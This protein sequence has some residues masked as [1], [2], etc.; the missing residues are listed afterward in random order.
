VAATIPPVG[1]TR[2][3]TI[4]AMRSIS[5][6]QRRQRLAARHRLSPTA[7]VDDDVAAVA[8][9]VVA[10]HASDPATMVLSAAQ[11]MRRPSTDAVEAALYDERT[12]VR[13]LG[14]RRT[15]FGVATDLV[16][17]VQVSSGDAVAA[18]ERR[19]L[20]GMLRDAGITSD[21]G[22]WLRRVERAVLTAIDAAG[23]V[24]AAELAALVPAMARR[25]P[26]AQGT[27]HAGTIGVASKV[28]F[29]L[30]AEGQLVRGRP[31]GRWTS[32]VHRWQRAET[33]LGR[34]VDRHLSAHEARTALARGWLERF[35]PATVADLRW[36]TGWTLGATRAALAALEVEEVDLDGMA[37]LVLAD[38]EPDPPEVPP[39]VALLPGLD[40]T[41]MGWKARAWYLGDH[42][43][44]VFDGN[45]NA[46]PTVWADG[47]VVGGWAQRADGEVVVRLLDDIGGDQAAQVAGE[48]SRLQDLL[49]A[50]RVTPRFPSPLDRALRA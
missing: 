47:R 41:T 45:G 26:V 7:R 1:L 39:W 35:G 10:L 12:V 46:G 42:G 4:V 6:A 3:A 17:V 32:G 11:R 38:D 33:W 30:A 31:T 29:Q 8:R 15:L 27:R 22:R 34:P 28:L 36:W 49:G 18:V 44:Q 50:V 23:E 20:E 14:M 21:P 43:T 37:G 25:I 13:M 24:T 9:S 2:S 40:P 5:V 19:R 16:G 48:A